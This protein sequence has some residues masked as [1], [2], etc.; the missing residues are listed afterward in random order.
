MA[1]LCRT[2]CSLPVMCVVW[3]W[4]LAAVAAWVCAYACSAH[5][6]S[7]VVCGTPP[8]LT[9]IDE[10][11]DE[12]FCFRICP[13]HR[14]QRPTRPCRIA[15]PPGPA[16]RP[17]R[18]RTRLTCRAAQTRDRRTSCRAEGSYVARGLPR[19]KARVLEARTWA[20][21]QAWR[22]SC[23]HT[24]KRRARGRGRAA[25]QPPLHTSSQ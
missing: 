23:S 25:I 22:C 6:D 5:A 16:P 20:V 4:A 15:A 12:T 11:A 19:N 2:P 17:A 8:V 21:S 24:Q 14:P 13:Q 1:K 18:A 3:R 10:I 9:K 7:C